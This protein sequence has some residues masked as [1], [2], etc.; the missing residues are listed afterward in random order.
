MVVQTSQDEGARVMIETS[1][2]RP[3]LHNLRRQIILFDSSKHWSEAGLSPRCCLLG[4]K[5]A[6]GPEPAPAPEC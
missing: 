6:V 4:V 1:R 3:Y 5:Y 2:L